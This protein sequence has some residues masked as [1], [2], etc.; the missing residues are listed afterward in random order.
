[1][2]RYQQQANFAFSTQTLAAQQ[3]SDAISIA[4]DTILQFHLV[5]VMELLPY[6]EQLVQS[7]LGFR[8]TSILSK[9]VRPH[10]HGK[11]HRTDSWTP[12]QSRGFIWATIG[13]WF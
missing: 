12:E 10:N 6:S 1:M 3:R 4:F 11:N 8:D 9:R 5:L 2:R 7:V 13:F